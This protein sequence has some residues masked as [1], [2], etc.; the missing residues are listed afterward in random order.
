MRVEQDRRSDSA[1][2]THTWGR[3][4]AER[5]KPGVCVLLVGDLGAGKTTLMRGIA[6]GLGIDPTEIHSPTFVLIHEH[7]GRLPL[8]HVD[9]Y[10]VSDPD[11]LVEVGLLEYLH[12]DGVTVIEWGDQVRTLVP[13]DAWEI[14]LHHVDEGRRRIELVVPS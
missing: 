10:R 8:Y 11:E 6:E 5:L 4:L 13:D 14:R 2:R 7:E 3:D 12:G 1:E 9:A